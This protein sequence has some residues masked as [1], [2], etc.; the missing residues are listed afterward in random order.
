MDSNK[1]F[2][3]AAI[4]FSLLVLN[5]TS[6]GAIESN[7]ENDTSIIT[8]RITSSLGYNI[9]DAEAYVSSILFESPM[10]Y[11]SEKKY[12]FK[13]I[14]QGL[15]QVELP[16][17][18]HF[19]I[20]VE[21]N[22]PD[23]S[24][25]FTTLQH[26]FFN[27]EIR[28]FHNNYYERCNELNFT[29]RFFSTVPY[30][31]GCII[32][33]NRLV[34]SFGTDSVTVTNELMDNNKLFISMLQD[35]SFYK[36]LPKNYRQSNTFEVRKK[37]YLKIIENLEL[38]YGLLKSSVFSEVISSELKK[39]D[40]NNN[41]K[42]ALTGIKFSNTVL[43]IADILNEFSLTAELLGYTIDLTN[44]AIKQQSEALFFYLAFQT[45]LEELFDNLEELSKK[46]WMSDDR[47]FLEAL[48]ER[49]VNFESKRSLTLQ[50][51]VDELMEGTLNEKLEDIV[52][53]VYAKLALKSVG[54]ALVS[55]TGVIKAA[56]AVK[57]TPI[58]AAYLV[59][60]LGKSIS[61]TVEYR[62][63]LSASINMD[64]YLF[65]S[66]PDFIGDNQSITLTDFQ[67][68]MS[69]IRIQ[70][71]IFFNEVRA[72]FLSGDSRTWLRRVFTSLSG[73][74]ISQEQAYSMEMVRVSLEKNQLAEKS[75]EL[76]NLE[77]EKR[78]RES[79][80]I[81]Q[82]VER[83]HSLEIC[84]TWTV[85]NSGGHEGTVDFWDISILPPNAILDIRYNMYNIPDK[86]V[87]EYPRNNIILNTGW[88]G[89]NSF[90]GPNYPGG[91]QGP[92]NGQVLDAFVK[93]ES[94][95]FVVFVTGGGSQTLW[96]YQV[97]CRIAN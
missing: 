22:A 72:G 88:R 86:L 97:R 33:P 61:K 29:T 82:Y 71:G 17:S 60:D 56:V 58:F 67:L 55:T 36:Y 64:R 44:T 5:N 73:I 28:L 30:W 68:I 70:N 7:S 92:G 65:G 37:A 38:T 87:L 42:Y 75:V 39:Y 35:V 83:W 31:D 53:E 14:D 18:G 11:F 21:V 76:I 12:H 32:D 45:S 1:I 23:H 13:H 26:L 41:V 93:N 66:F 94:N 52:L 85:A 15:Y 50:Q 95:E 20:R 78:F 96:E 80:S 3:Y 69:L 54:K 9:I 59:Y 57:A 16:Y 43:E 91:I 79:L 84:E 81:D 48:H 77:L 40:T 19:K 25:M 34:E 6:W 90:A 51:V 27:Q 10:Y 8:I 46:S 74:A 24:F 4:I 47:A 49:R 62:A 89:S 63:L 2:T